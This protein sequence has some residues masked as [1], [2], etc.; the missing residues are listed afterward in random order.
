MP[1]GFESS[2][3]ELLWMTRERGF[4]PGDRQEKHAHRE[5][6]LRQYSSMQ[7]RRDPAKPEGSRRAY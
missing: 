7:G 1:P 6:S 3:P 5:G 2:R 4:V